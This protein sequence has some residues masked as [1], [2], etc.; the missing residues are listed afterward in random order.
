MEK[1]NI[2]CDTC[3]TG[4]FKFQNRMILLEELVLDRIIKGAQFRPMAM[5]FTPSL[6]SL[7]FKFVDKFSD[8][9]RFCWISSVAPYLE[10]V[11]L[12][13][14]HQKNKENGSKILQDMVASFVLWKHVKKFKVSIGVSPGPL[15]GVRKI[16]LQLRGIDCSLRY[17]SDWNISYI[18]V[19]LQ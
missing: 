5:S 8:E 12:S 1:L 3:S 7:D 14:P 9:K 18:S 19:V 11:S 16:Y 10:S 6:K 13:E 17:I 4:T 2:S 15:E